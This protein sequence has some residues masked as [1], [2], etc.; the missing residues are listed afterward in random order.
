MNTS[1]LSNKAVTV[2]EGTRHAAGTDG[3][4]IYFVANGA[5]RGMLDGIFEAPR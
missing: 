3:A 4:S 5:L 2:I 1:E